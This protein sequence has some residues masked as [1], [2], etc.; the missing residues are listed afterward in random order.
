MLEDEPDVMGIIWVFKPDGTRGY[1]CRGIGPTYDRFYQEWVPQSSYR[2]TGDDWP[3]DYFVFDDERD[4]AILLMDFGD[5][6]S[7]EGDEKG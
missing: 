5:I 1:R 6:V 4:H 2:C 3:W 7:Y